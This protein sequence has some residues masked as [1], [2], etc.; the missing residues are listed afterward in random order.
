[1]AAAAMPETR[2]R[3]RHAIPSA[4]AAYMR[5]WRLSRFARGIYLYELAWARRM[6]YQTWRVK[7]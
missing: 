7:G 3:K 5:L 1:M 6:A 2:G 4:H